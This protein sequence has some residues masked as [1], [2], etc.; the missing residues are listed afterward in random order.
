VVAAENFGANMK[1]NLN[2][3]VVMFTSWIASS[4]M[5]ATILVPS[6][7]PTIQAA[8]NIAVNGDQIIVAPGFYGE[9][10]D[11]KGKAVTLKASGDSSNTFITPNSVAGAIISCITSEPAG[12]VIQG[13]T[14]VSAN[15]AGIAITSS[16][17]VFKF[18]AISQNYNS[19]ANGGGVA[20]TGTGGSPRFE[21]CQFI[22]NRAIGREGGAIAASATNG[23]LTCLRCSF[24]SNEATGSFGGAIYS[25]GT[26]VNLTSCTFTSNSVNAGGGWGVWDIRMGGAIY[27]TGAGLTAAGCAFSGNAVTVVSSGNSDSATGGGAIASAGTVNVS[28]SIFS[29]NRSECL[30]A[31]CGWMGRAW[32]GALY[33]TGAGLVKFQSC[34]FTA[35]KSLNTGTTCGREARGGAVAVQNSCD[36]I[37][38]TCTFTSNQ[39]ESQNLSYQAGGTFWWD[40]NCTGSIV[41][42]TV[43]ASTAGSEGGALFLNDGA[44]PFVLRTIFSNCSTTYVN[45]NGGAVRAQNVANAYFSNCRFTNCSSP[46]GG[47][48]Y[49]RN[50]QP[51]FSYCTFDNNT[52][53]L[54]SA[55]R[56][57]GSGI[58]NVPTVQYSFFCSNSGA[59][60]NW[61]LGNWNNPIRTSNSFNASCGSDCNANGIL[62][63]AE[64][65]SG[66]QPD[67]DSNGQPD[68]CQ[69]DC[70]GDGVINICEIL[71]GAADCDGNLVPDSCQ[72]AQ[73]ATDVNN[74]GI[75]DSC[76]PVDF[77]GLKTVVVPIVERSADSTIPTGAVCFRVYAEFTNA[78]GA[79]WGIYGNQDSPMVIGAAGGFYNAASV[80]NLSNTI[81]CDTTSVPHGVRYD[82]WLTVGAQ[83]ENDNSLQQAGFDFTNFSSLGINDNDCIAY[84]AP[85]SAQGVAGATKRVLV[86]QLTTVNGILPTGRFNIVGRNG[87]GTD[88]LAFGQTWPQPTLVDCNANGIHD[89]FDIR[90]GIAKDC[91][92]SG[93]PDSC[94]YANPNEDCNSNG[95]ADLCD[96]QSGASLDQNANHVPDECECAGDVDGDGTVN[97]DD[98]VWVILAWGDIGPS[99]ADLNGDN[100]VNAI[101]LGLVLTYYG[102]CQ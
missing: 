32:G 64:I 80:G 90:D 86:A 77:V 30:Q 71:N 7:Q 29:Q 16:S 65:A 33:L 60:T 8:I 61:I 36:P 66:A 99:P 37:F 79:V 95:V 5:S 55:I 6:Q 21:D 101:D 69:L 1:S 47:A 49:T 25:S 73:G 45:S 62:D 4:A 31:N 50:S 39:T 96:I 97:V 9:R 3:A 42:C 88:L 28:N 44:S 82:S 2:L 18:C 93:I 84:V 92:E 48:V 54:G 74:D 83:C 87:S 27:M 35:N 13:F 70:D 38:D 91:D 20:Y 81:P 58:P 14:I 100:V 57:E 102:S 10:I 94:E 52:S 78:N 63:S 75:L 89:A 40:I 85:G 19:A 43:S 15:G 56:T 51:F 67:C 34:T 68:S 76:V 46:N 72:I 17:P 24:A 23:V 26:A 12:C 59:S 41:D 11:M 22:G 53:A 98:I